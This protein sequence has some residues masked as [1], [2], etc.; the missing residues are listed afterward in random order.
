MKRAPPSDGDNMV[1]FDSTR[2]YESSEKIIEDEMGSSPL[3]MDGIDL[4]EELIDPEEGFMNSE[5]Y[6][7]K[8]LS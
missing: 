1:D 5:N 2:Q 8:D 4:D 3:S 6:D 7:D